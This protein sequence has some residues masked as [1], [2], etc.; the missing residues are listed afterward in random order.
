MIAKIL[1]G[2]IRECVVPPMSVRAL[3]E[4]KLLW[5][6]DGQHFQNDCV[7]EGENRCVGADA[8]GEREHGD[9]R[10]PGILSQ[11]AKP[12]PK[13]L[14]QALE[15]RQSP[16]LPMLFLGLLHAPKANERLAAG[17]LRCQAATNIFLG[18]QGYVGFELLLK[19]FIDAPA[20]ERSMNSRS[21]NS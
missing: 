16:R 3:G 9:H 15:R 17:F 21:Q 4:D 5:T 2:G 1:I 18:E 8:E 20:R 10:K 7:N 6:L 11:R 14:H 13:I 12:K 19:I